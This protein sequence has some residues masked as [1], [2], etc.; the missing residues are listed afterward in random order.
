MI[1]PDLVFLETTVDDKVSRIRELGCDVFVDDLL[2]VLSAEN[3]PRT[4]RRLLFN[5]GK[6][7]RPQREVEQFCSWG[8][9]F[10]LLGLD[11]PGGSS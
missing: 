8:E 6:H 4:T 2:E 5:P 10:D 7:Q 9:L 3:F 11:E 1:P